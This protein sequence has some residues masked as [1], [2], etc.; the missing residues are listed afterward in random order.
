MC[1]SFKFLTAVHFNSSTTSTSATA[2]LSPV[3]HYH[4]VLIFVSLLFPN[5]HHYGILFILT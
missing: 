5:T 3:Y 2:R 1:H 4:P